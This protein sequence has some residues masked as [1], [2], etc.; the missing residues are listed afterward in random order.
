MSMVLIFVGLLITIWKT[1]FVQ[2]CCFAAERREWGNMYGYLLA[3]KENGNVVAS[4]E[5]KTPTDSALATWDIMQE[6]IERALVIHG[7]YLPSRET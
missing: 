4:T 5:D 1:L 2:K 3:V 7:R 6:R